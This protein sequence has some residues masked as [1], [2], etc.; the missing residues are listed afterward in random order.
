MMEVEENEKE[1][2]EM[3]Q[4]DDKILQ[5]RVSKY[6][7]ELQ[8]LSKI[9]R[10]I[11]E[12]NDAMT[13]LSREEVLAIGLYRSFHE[14]FVKIPGTIKFMEEFMSL[15]RSYDRKARQEFVEVLKRRPSYQ[16]EYGFLEEPEDSQTPGRLSKIVGFLRGRRR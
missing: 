3:V 2:D 1:R 10:I 6:S 13:E 7:P 14:N 16:G 8:R 11:T 12:M 15:M 5:E 9:D 4:E